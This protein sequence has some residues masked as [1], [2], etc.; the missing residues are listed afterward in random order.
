[1]TFLTKYHVDKHCQFTH[2]Y[3]IGSW[4]LLGSGDWDGNFPVEVENNQQGK[5]PF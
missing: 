5:N 2:E 1:M 4:L 3:Q